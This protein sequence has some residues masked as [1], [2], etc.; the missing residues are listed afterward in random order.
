[1]LIHQLWLIWT[2]GLLQ[3][4]EHLHELVII[5]YLMSIEY[6]MKNGSSTLAPQE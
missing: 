2:G 6:L 4:H 3:T 1:M 5:E